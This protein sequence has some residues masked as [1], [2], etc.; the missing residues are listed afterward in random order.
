MQQ[1]PPSS[2]IT[3]LRGVFERHADRRWLFVR[4][5]GN[6]GDQLIYA[7]AE[8]L[9]ADIGL[10][11]TTCSA[12]KFPETAVSS[13]QC[14]YLH[15][16]GGYNTWCSGRVFL[17]LEHAVRQDVPLVV[18]G[19]Q[20]TQAEP[21]G[22]IERLHAALE[23]TRCREVI[24]FAR[25]A[26]SLNALRPLGR[27]EQQ[28][29]Q[30]AL[31]HDTALHL[32]ADDLCRLA[33]LQRIPRGRYR[34][35]VSRGDNERPQQSRSQPKPGWRQGVTLDPAYVA[36]N[37]AHWIQIHLYAHSITT[38]RLH[39]AIVGSIAGK[40]VTLGPG[41]YHKNHSVWELSL[42]QRNVKW[43]EHVDLSP[44]SENCWFPRVICESY[45]LRWLWLAA[46]GVP[47]RP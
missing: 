42:A 47:M 12:E 14:I 29:I 38:N 13:D 41:S 23:H 6:W 10:T 1:A 8:R 20:S 35:N 45:K 43:S 27:L 46:H 15:G 33:Q 7:G 25:D 44:A 34:L 21:D 11:W 40:P 9:A 30:L 26:V 17:N 24:F 22:L 18:Q 32:Q 4:P 28:G 5:G 37:F 2:A 36:R 31:D 16:G 19:P 3:P 39:S